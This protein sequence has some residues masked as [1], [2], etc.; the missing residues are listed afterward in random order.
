MPAAMSSNRISSC[1]TG[2][3]SDVPRQAE[4][5]VSDHPV[6]S[7]RVHG[8]S[9]RLREAAAVRSRPN[10]DL[11]VADQGHGENAATRS[12]GTLRPPMRSFK[13]QKRPES[14]RWDDP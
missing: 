12:E 9:S 2:N 14:G 1:A 13:Q 8:L 5:S 7:S 3:A 10:P 6:N 11:N 4:G